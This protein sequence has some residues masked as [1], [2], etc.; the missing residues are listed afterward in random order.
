[1]KCALCKEEVQETF[2]NKILGTFIGKKAVCANCQKS[3]S[4]EAIKAKL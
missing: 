4:M 1:M 2:L 3:N